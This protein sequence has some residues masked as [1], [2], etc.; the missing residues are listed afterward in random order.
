[1]AATATRLDH[2]TPIALPPSNVPERSVE[3]G[4][5]IVEVHCQRGRPPDDYE[6]DLLRCGVPGSPVGFTE[7]AARPVS[8]D[9]VAKMAADRKS[10]PP[11][12]IGLL[13]Q[14]DQGWTVDPLPLLEERLKIGA[15]CQPLVSRQPPGQTVSRFRPFA[16]RRFNVFRPPWV[17]I[18]S[19]KPWVFAR[20]RR[21]G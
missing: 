21:F 1:M 6:V 14:D 4:D 8:L 10:D 12:R 9:G 18:R 19:R 17:F 3:L 5:E 15:A 20:R 7:P 2:V 16:R 11:R 13:P